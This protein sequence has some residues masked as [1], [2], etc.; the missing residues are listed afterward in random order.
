MKMV[1]RNINSGTLHKKLKSLTLVTQNY[2]Q[3]LNCT[4]IKQHIKHTFDTSDNY[5]T[6]YKSV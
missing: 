2:Q 1:L 3:L 4:I 6:K 5:K